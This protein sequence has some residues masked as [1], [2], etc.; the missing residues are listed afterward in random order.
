VGLRGLGAGG[1]AP[2]PA[3]HASP[4]TAARWLF[5]KPGQR[6]QPGAGSPAVP[7]LL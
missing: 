5:G 6:L 3:P 1:L 2:S 4:S 7:P